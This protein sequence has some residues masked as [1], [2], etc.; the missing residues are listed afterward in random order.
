[1]DYVSLPGKSVPVYARGEVI[2]VGGGPA[3]ISAAVASVRQGCKTV[4]IDEGGILGGTVTKCLMPSFGSLNFKLIK[5]LFYEVCEKL[6]EKGAL[7][8][9]E[10]RSSPF[11]PEAFKSIIFDLI[12]KERVDLLLHTTVFDV[13][14]RGNSLVGVFLT[15]KFGIQAILGDVVIDA[16]GDGDVAALAGEAFDQ[17][18]ERQPMSL[19]FTL[20]NADVRRFAAFV[21]DYPEKNEFTAMGNPLTFD[22]DRIDENQPQVNAWGF[23]SSIKQA[24]ASGELYLPHDNLAVVFLP[25][26][27][28]VFVNATNVSNLNPLSPADLTTAE[29]ESRKQ[30]VSVHQFLKSRIPGF[31]NSFLMAS[32]SSIGVRESRRLVGRYVLTQGDVLNEGRFADAIAVNGG[33]ISIH[34]SDEKQTWIKLKGPYQIPYRSL[35]GKVSDNLLV[36]GRCLS[37]DHVAG[38]S[39]RNVTACFA[40]GQAAGTAAALAVKN[41]VKPAKLD[42][43]LLQKALSAQGVVLYP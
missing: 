6:T 15:G 31:E 22:V 34:G 14:K 24:R 21:R 13:I 12:E 27:G 26:K 5:G 32:G 4:L 3:G 11:D 1:M 18:Q 38:G 43:Q 41:K 16:T 20:G 29:V 9:N 17:S 10:G 37:A 2:V 28:V 19:M 42:V 35:Q 23:F 40:T 30:M 25:A 36:A 33:R 8:L 39:M 7:I